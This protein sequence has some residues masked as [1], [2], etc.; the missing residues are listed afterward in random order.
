MNY[1]DLSLRVQEN[2]DILASS[3][4]G[5]WQGKLN[6]DHKK[7]IGLAMQLIEKDMTDKELLQKVGSTLFGALFN[8]NISSNLAAIKAHADEKEYGVR[9]RLTFEDPEYASIPWEFLYDDNTNTFLA[10]DPKTAISRYI[11]VPLKKQDI[12]PAS[13]PLR[14]LLVISSPDDM[15]HLD[16]DGEEK[17]IRQALQDHVSSGQI[18]IDTITQATINEIDQRLNEK[19]YNVLHFIGHGVFENNKGFIVLMDEK[20][21][22]ELLDEER[23]ANL[24]LDKKGLGLVILN[25][26]E[27]AKRSSSQVFAGMAP[28]LVRRGIPAIIAMQYSIR[29]STAKLF[30]DKF[31]RS[32]A[33]G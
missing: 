17:L 24:F 3:D 18:E 15:P 30:A 28:H 31:Y 23:F 13:L 20:G 1:Y 11:S 25:S 9:L 4:Q 5:E 2:G 33:L 10:N 27:G 22:A 12:K 21:H 19:P 29:D 16:S 8:K 14:M 26:C 7:E 32:L 6:L